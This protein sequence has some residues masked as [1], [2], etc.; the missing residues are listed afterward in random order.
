MI[1]SELWQSVKKGE[2]ARAKGPCFSMKA[3][4]FTRMAT[5][6]MVSNVKRK[7]LGLDRQAED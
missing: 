1:H 4:G 6:L 3:T 5:R 2:S 7:V